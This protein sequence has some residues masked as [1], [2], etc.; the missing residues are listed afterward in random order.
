MTYAL[1]RPAPLI[2]LNS[3]LFCRIYEHL[4]GRGPIEKVAKSNKSGHFSA[5][6]RGTRFKTTFFHYWWWSNA[7]FEDQILSQNST[8]LCNGGLNL[9]RRG[10]MI[11]PPIFYVFIFRGDFPFAVRHMKKLQV[12]FLSKCTAIAQL[13]GWIFLV[14]D[15]HLFG[16]SWQRVI[17]Q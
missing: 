8:S 5:V 2:S 17:Y 7:F 10:S 9:K 11:F 3:V 4:N 13:W 14:A 16:I 1:D 15:L 6:L 12:S